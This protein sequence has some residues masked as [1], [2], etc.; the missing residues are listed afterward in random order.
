[1][2]STLYAFPCLLQKLEV[3]RDHLQGVIALDQPSRVHHR[4]KLSSLQTQS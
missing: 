1:M 4:W 3:L 2:P